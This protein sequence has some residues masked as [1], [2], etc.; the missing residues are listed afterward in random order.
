MYFRKGVASANLTATEAPNTTNSLD[1]YAYPNG[2]ARD[3]MYVVVKFPV[4]ALDA[5]KTCDIAIQH[6]DDNGSGAPGA[7]TTIGQIPQVL[8]SN[9][10]QTVVYKLSGPTKAHIGLN[11]VVNAGCAFGKVAAY[12]TNEHPQL[13]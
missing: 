5:T 11:I 8:Q 6:A 12:L 1:V 4:A 2:L 7:Y 13:V 3:G 10:Q 9:V